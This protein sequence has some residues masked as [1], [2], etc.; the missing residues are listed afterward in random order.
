MNPC[1]YICVTCCVRLSATAT[2]CRC[3]RHVRIVT[4][5]VS[6]F[7]TSHHKIN[8]DIAQHNC[9]QCFLLHQGRLLVSISSFNTITVCINSKNPGLTCLFVMKI[10]FVFAIFSASLFAVS[11]SI[12]FDILQ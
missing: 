8:L 10:Y 6:S 9:L 1:V 7:N 4:C 12:T 2:S 11:Q 5:S 3:S